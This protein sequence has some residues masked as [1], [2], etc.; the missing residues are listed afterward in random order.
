[1]TGHTRQPAPAAG[2][3]DDPPGTSSARPP[4]LA[5]RSGPGMAPAPSHGGSSRRR[6]QA[7]KLY[8]HTH[9]PAGQRNAGPSAQAAHD[10]PA[11]QK[12]GATIH[13]ATYPP[14]AS[15]PGRTPAKPPAKSKRPRPGNARPQAIQHA[16]HTRGDQNARARAR[17]G[18]ARAPAP[19]AGRY[20]QNFCRFGAK[21]PLP[22]ASEHALEGGQKSDKGRKT[23]AEDTK[24]P[25]ELHGWQTGG[26][27]FQEILEKDFNFS[28]T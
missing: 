1:M 15:V 11:P 12:K 5:R 6:Q 17:K 19:I 4:Q 26:G 28:T 21:K 10:R 14:G 8:A 13:R 9:T 7:R 27:G 23:G 22:P 3:P 24:N 25:P 16:T 20:A 2:P 18:T